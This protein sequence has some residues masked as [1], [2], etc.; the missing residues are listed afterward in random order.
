MLSPPIESPTNAIQI[1]VGVFAIEDLLFIEKKGYGTY[2][3][4]IYTEGGFKNNPKIESETNMKQ[5]FQARL[6]S[7]GL[8]VPCCI[9][10]EGK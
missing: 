7:N 8:D 5:C 4:E 6:P 2:D 1:D 10:D 9:N 3:M